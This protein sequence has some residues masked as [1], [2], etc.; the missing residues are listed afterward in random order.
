MS[1]NICKVKNIDSST[2]T[3]CGQ[4]ITAGSTY[5]ILDS[6]R[7]SWTVSDTLISDI[8]ADKAEIWDSVAAINTYSDQINWLKNYD[9][10]PQDSD[11]SDLCRVKITRTGWGLQCHAVQI[12]TAKL[13]SIYNRD[14]DGDDYGFTTLKFYNASDVE[15]TDA[16][17][18]STH[19]DHIDALCVRTDLIWEPTFDIEM[20][21]GEFWQATAPTNDIYMWFFHEY[22]GHS[23]CDG[24]MNAKVIGAAHKEMDGRAPKL[25]PYNDTYHT[26]RLIL[27][28]RH[29]AG[30]Q[31]KIMLVLEYYKA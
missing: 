12:E 13:S 2:H 3:Y 4:E 19:Q 11:G 29:T 17:A 9:Y 1:F 22:S 16:G 18:Y 10:H 15:I 21:G 30:D 24:G 31:H 28:C 27:R 6:E 23:F 20:I 25:L 8:S 7:I 14:K 5:T 26:G